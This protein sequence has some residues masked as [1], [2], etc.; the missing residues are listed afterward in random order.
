MLRFDHVAIVVDD[1]DAAAAFF[2][3]LGFERVGA[4]LVEGED[5]DRINGLDGVRASLVTVRTPDH[6]ASLELVKYLSPPADGRVQALPAN[7]LGLRHICFEVEDLN[8]IVDRLRAKG[9]SPVGDV[10][11][12]T[13]YAFRLVYVRGPEGLIIEFGERLAA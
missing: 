7:A 11:D 12:Y 10:R 13:D 2:C 5:V 3:D 6:S 9:F 4:A 1:L 8:G